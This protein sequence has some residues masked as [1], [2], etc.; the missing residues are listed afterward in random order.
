MNCRGSQICQPSRICQ[1][2]SLR[3]HICRW[4]R[5][6]FA[7]RAD[8]AAVAEFADRAAGA[9]F[10]DRA[11]GANGTDAAKFA[12]GAA[13]AKLDDKAAIAK[14]DNEAARAKYDD[15]A[16]FANGAESMM[17]IRNTAG[18]KFAA[19]PKYLPTELPQ[20]S[21]EPQ[22]PNLLFSLVAC[23]IVFPFSNN[24]LTSVLFLQTPKIDTI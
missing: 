18:P 24:I 13:G 14:L 20:L 5:A 17:L 6:A 23:F 9:K 7:D 8:F 4:S 1:P 11:A 19:E 21:T 12:D 22:D 16:E 2:I 10:A 15:G 3:C